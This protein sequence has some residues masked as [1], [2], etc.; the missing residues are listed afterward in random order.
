M[1][2]S[3]SIPTTTGLLAF[4]SLQDTNKL[5]VLGANGTGKSA[6]L[7]HIYQQL[8]ERAH[9]VAAYRQTY[10]ESGTLDMSGSQ[11]RAA[12]DSLSEWDGSSQSRYTETRKRVL[13]HKSDSGGA[14]A[15][16]TWARPNNRSTCRW[17]RLAGR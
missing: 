14:F 16:S 12:T 4:R 2:Q 8:P 7:H 5:F 15:K 11:Y 3:V 13:A 9:K 6:L 17:G 1:E 10:L